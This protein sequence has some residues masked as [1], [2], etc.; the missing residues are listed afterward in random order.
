LKRA[1]KMCEEEEKYL[2]NSNERERPL[3]LLYGQETFINSVGFEGNP[4]LFLNDSFLED[5]FA[6]LEPH[7][8]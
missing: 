3:S 1:Q 2:C 4:L 7:R 5:W 8:I 6:S